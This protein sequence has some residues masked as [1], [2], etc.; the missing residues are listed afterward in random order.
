METDANEGGVRRRGAKPRSRRWEIVHA[1][2][3]NTYFGLKP[4][5][6]VFYRMVMALGPQDR[7]L[8]KAFERALKAMDAFD[9]EAQLARD[10]R[11]KEVE[12]EQG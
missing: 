9:C 2:Q 1:W 8:L 4:L 5:R 6:A 12:R 3:W 10:R 7:R 11:L